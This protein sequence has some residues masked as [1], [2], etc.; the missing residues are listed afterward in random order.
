MLLFV[1]QASGSSS[2]GFWAPLVLMAIVMYFFFIRPQSKK[3]K[4]QNT[5]MSELE[6]GNH[7]VTSSGILGKINKIE[8]N[9]VT[10]QVD[11]K[12]FIQ[13]TKGSISREMT[14]AVHKASKDDEKK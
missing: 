6:K 4:D 10:L 5:F 2:L 9:I 1:L 12:T 13:V 14:D 7:V 11:S 3:Q 8:D